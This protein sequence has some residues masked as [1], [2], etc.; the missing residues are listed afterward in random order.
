M[1]LAQ[2]CYSGSAAWYTLSGFVIRNAVSEQ[3]H[4]IPHQAKAYQK[5]LIITWLGC[6][7]VL[8]QAYAGNLTAMLSKPK[9]HTPIKTLDEL[10]GQNEISWVI[11]KG[12]QAEHYMQSASTGTKLSL[13]HKRAALVP[14][15]TPTE[16]AIYGCYPPRLRGKKS[17]GS[18][19]GLQVIWPMIAKDFSE[20][21][22]CNFY[23]IE[24]RLYSSL[25]GAAFQVNISVTILSPTY[26][27]GF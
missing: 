3:N 7:L 20:T 12:S 24:E 5:I 26:F 6:A 13:L 25:S 27:S 19:C 10:L 18:F 2:Y 14:Q 4:S 8:V 11:E 22:R 9:F 15:L 16:Q 17:I 21:G 23:L 1:C